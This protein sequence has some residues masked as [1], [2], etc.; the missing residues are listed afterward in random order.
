[1]DIIGSKEKAVAVI[2]VPEEQAEAAVEEIRKR[3]KHVKSIL[4][5]IGGREG[6]Y[7]ICN[8]KLIWGSQDTEVIHK[9]N[10]YLLKLDP[11]RVY[12]SPREATERQ[13]I[14]KLVK[15]NER[16]L[17]MFSGVAPYA[18][19]I[20]KAQ[21]DVE[22]IVCVDINLVATQ[23]ATE[24]VKLNKLDDKI[25]V[26]CWDV[27]EASGLG[28]FDRIIMPLPETGYQYIDVAH[29]SAKEHAIIHLYGISE[30]KDFS[31]FEKKLKDYAQRF[32][33]KI[34][35]LRKSKVS[36]YAP[37]KVKVRFDFQFL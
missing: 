17:V 36:E 25:K 29:R 10:K 16:V 23:Y 15:P 1:M 9:E 27:R 6:V 3:Y 30:T 32:G 28:K 35:I 19:A 20:A 13:R 11:L 21:K 14:A 31:D 24:N 18:I 26:Y 8:T 7:R 2:D 22:E 34:K 37:H 5:K 33:I 12:F 4:L